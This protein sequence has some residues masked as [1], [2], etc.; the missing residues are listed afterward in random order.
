MK[1]GYWS[2]GGQEYSGTT[3]LQAPGNISGLMQQ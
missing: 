1:G 3:L 2:A